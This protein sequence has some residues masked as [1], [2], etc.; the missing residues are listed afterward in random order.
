[1]TTVTDI[2]SRAGAST[3]FMCDFSPPRTPSANWPDEA[4]YLNSDL[5]CVP[6]LAPHPTR[7]D[8]ITAAHLVRERTGTELVFNFATRDAGKSEVWERLGNARSLG[9]ENMVVLHGDADRGVGNVAREDSFKPTELIRELQ[10]LDEGFCVGAVADL[11]KGVDQEAI[12]SRRKIDAG[13]DFLLV[14]PTFDIDALERFLAKADTSTPHVLRGPG[15][16]KRRRCIRPGSRLPA[17]GYRKWTVGGGCRE[18]DDI[19]FAPNRRELLLPD[20]SYIP[21]WDAGLQRSAQ[22]NGLFRKRVGISRTCIMGP[23]QG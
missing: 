9:L 2:V 3:V 15:A 7:P 10:G 19:Q 14:Q 4:L 22:G 23:A 12:L 8:A 11:A 16:G 18:G 17:P 13:A 6:H 1:M 5:I 21:G 20:S